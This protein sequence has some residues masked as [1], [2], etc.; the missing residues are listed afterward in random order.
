MNISIKLDG[1][2]ELIVLETETEEE[3]SFLGIESVDAPR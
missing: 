3:Y 2:T 1:V